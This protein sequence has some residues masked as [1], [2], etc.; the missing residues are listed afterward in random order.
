MLICSSYS[1]LIGRSS[2]RRQLPLQVILYNGSTA[3][4]DIYSSRSQLIGG[5]AADNH[6]ILPL[7][8]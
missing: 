6:S 7:C 8:N 2:D 3:A 4:Y 1:Q 5:K